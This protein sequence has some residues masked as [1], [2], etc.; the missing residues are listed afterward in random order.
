M[1]KEL[2]SNSMTEQKIDMNITKI[3]KHKKIKKIKK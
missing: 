3:D 2:N 1:Q